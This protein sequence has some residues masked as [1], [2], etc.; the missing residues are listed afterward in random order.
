[1][2]Y[3]WISKLFLSRLNPSAMIYN[4]YKDKNEIK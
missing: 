4:G 1:M 3:Q 2:H